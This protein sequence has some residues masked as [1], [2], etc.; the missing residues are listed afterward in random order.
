[1]SI[2]PRLFSTPRRKRGH[3]AR[4]CSSHWSPW[5]KRKAISHHQALSNLTEGQALL[6]TPSSRSFCFIWAKHW[7]PE[8]SKQGKRELDN[9][10]AGQSN[11]VNWNP[12]TLVP[13]HGKH[14]LF[15]S[16]VISSTSKFASYIWIERCGWIT[17]VN[18]KL[19]FIM[20]NQYVWKQEI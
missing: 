17:Q 13:G 6:Q 19:C 15:C 9:D 18:E 12:F 2:T 20:K 4:F 5:P 7:Q 10:K 8:S 16:V 11:E 14:G 3:S 1:M